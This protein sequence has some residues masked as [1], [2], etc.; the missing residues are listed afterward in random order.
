MAGDNVF[1]LTWRNGV[2]FIRDSGELGNVQSRPL[3]SAIREG[4]GLCSDSDSLFVSDGSDHLY[5][6]SLDDLS[7]KQTIRVTSHGTPL[8]GLNELEFVRG[9]IWANLYSTFCIAR[10]SPSSGAVRCMLLAALHPHANSP[11]THFSLPP[12]AG[13]DRGFSRTVSRR[14]PCGG[15]HERN[16]GQPC[17]RAH[18][19]E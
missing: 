14:T 15:R 10:I 4:W 9:E 13:L 8:R 17:E 1:Q 18:L 16:C 19:R 5:R 3:P 2:M 6:L 11:H 7:L 12:V